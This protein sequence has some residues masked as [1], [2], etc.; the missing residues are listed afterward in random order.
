MSKLADALREM[1]EINAALFRAISAESEAVQMGILDRLEA[2]QKKLGI[3]DGYGTRARA[4]LAADGWQPIETAPSIDRWAELDLWL[5]APN[6]RQWREAN[7]RYDPSNDSWIGPDGRWV[8]GAYKRNEW[9]DE[10]FDP[11][12]KSEKAIRATHWQP[13]PAPPKE[14][15]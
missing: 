12:D 9:G 2:E 8:Q 14:K 13:L 4:A 10:C 15:P 6:G 1:T 11:S 5:V 7:C 3:S